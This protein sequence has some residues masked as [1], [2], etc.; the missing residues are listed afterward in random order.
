MLSKLSIV[1][2]TTRLLEASKQGN[3]S[4]IRDLASRK[5]NLE[6]TDK[7]KR[8]DVIHDFIS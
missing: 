8:R 5:I 7:V 3:E 2:D 1:S 4:D 6:C